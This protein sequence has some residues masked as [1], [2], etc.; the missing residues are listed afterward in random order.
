[1]AHLI[2]GRPSPDLIVVK[3][4][5]SFDPLNT[6]EP[7]TRAHQDRTEGG[8]LLIIPGVD[9]KYH[10]PSH[11]QLNVIHALDSAIKAE[12]D[13]QEA[14]RRLL[15]RFEDSAGFTVRHDVLDPG[16]FNPL[17]RFVLNEYPDQV[18]ELKKPSLSI[19]AP[20]EGI[21]ASERGRHNRM[22]LPIVSRAMKETTAWINAEV[23][24]PRIYDS[25]GERGEKR[26]RYIALS[27]DEQSASY[28]R[29]ERELFASAL[30]EKGR[31]LKK[32]YEPHVSLFVTDD[33]EVA[34][35]VLA[36]VR[37]YVAK[38]TTLRFDKPR[39]TPV[40]SR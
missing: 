39:L 27:I 19:V 26:R 25:A 11:R 4:G 9:R 13:K 5:L 22:V 33:G 18:R 40:Q 32:H 31:M 16:W 28:I 21:N 15:A 20:Q 8:S 24:E 23:G 1:M 17:I 30:A 14:E 36:A 37:W 34:K 38:G 12:G 29:E 2:E 3:Y 6:F 10:T 35:Q 7:S